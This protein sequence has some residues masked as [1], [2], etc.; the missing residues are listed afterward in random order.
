M[1]TTINL[2]GDSRKGPRW[3]KIVTG[4]DKKQTGGYSILG[5]FVKHQQEYDLPIGTIIICVGNKGSWKNAW[6][7]ADIYKVNDEYENNL[8]FIKEYDYKKIVT[9]QEKLT[10]LLNLPK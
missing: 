2:I 10:E 7:V 6:T 8:E 1:K 5:D 9:I 4:I 3:G